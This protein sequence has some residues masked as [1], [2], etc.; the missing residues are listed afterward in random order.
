MEVGGSTEADVLAGRHRQRS[1]CCLPC[2]RQCVGQC[3]CVERRVRMCGAMCVEQRVRMCGVVCAERCV[4][5]CGAECVERRVTMVCVERRVRMCGALCVERAA[6]EA[7]HGSALQFW[8]ACRLSGSGRHAAQTAP[9][10]HR[11]A[12]VRV[13]WKG[14]IPFS[15]APACR[16]VSN[17][18]VRLLR[19]AGF[20]Q[21]IIKE[22]GVRALWK[23][24]TPFATHLTLKYALRMFS[25]A[26]YQVGCGCGP[27]RS[28]CLRSPSRR[29]GGDVDSTLLSNA[30]YRI[31][32]RLWQPDRAKS[33][34]QPQPNPNLNLPVLK[35]SPD[36]LTAHPAPTPDFT[37]SPNA[38]NAHPAPTP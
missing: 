7:M 2:S 13:L 32:C 31:G 4:R 38:L 30:Q 16:R 11:Q 36:A 33:E 28:E 9:V 34:A 1:L 3:V 17:G 8:D 35:H 26:Q 10:R 6:C 21:T 22:E 29:R 25:N 5:M 15:E 18:A 27:T 23:G 24:L 14:M 37:P 19:R 12:C 20:S